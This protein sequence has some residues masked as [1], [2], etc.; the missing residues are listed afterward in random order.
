MKSELPNSVLAGLNLPEASPAMFQVSP[1]RCAT[2]I[3]LL[4]S[5]A[6]LF[7]VLQT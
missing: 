3:W 5:Y 7:V 6:V 2:G 1:T 4:E